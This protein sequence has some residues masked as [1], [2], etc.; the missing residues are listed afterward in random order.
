METRLKLLEAAIRD[1]EAVELAAIQA[2][3][4]HDRYEKM[5]SFTLQVIGLAVMVVSVLWII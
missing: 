4:K 5:L 1:M 3:G 2:K